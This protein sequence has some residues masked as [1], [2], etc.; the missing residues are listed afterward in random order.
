M[1]YNIN[2]QSNYNFMIWKELIRE[3]QLIS[4][5]CLYLVIVGHTFYTTK[6]LWMFLFP[7]TL[8]DLHKDIIYPSL[9]KP[10]GQNVNQLIVAQWCHNAANIWVNIGS[11]NGFPEITKTEPGLMWN[12]YWWNSEVVDL[13]VISQQ[14]VQI[15]L[16]TLTNLKIIFPVD[17]MLCVPVE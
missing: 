10:I 17:R 7:A 14:I 8:S 9:C 4:V 1:Q 12:C 2:L 16:Y 6:L 3:Y 13:G 5:K 11:G 15:M